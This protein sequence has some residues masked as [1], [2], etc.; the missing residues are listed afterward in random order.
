[1]KT[2][3]KILYAAVAVAILVMATLTADCAPGD[4]FASINNGPGNGVG[5]IYQ[6]TPAGVQSTVASGLSHPRGLAFDS[7]ANLF[8]AT[9]F[10]K[11]IRGTLLC[12][13]TILQIAPNGAQSVFAT[14][15]AFFATGVAIDHSDNVFVM[16]WQSTLAP[17]GPSIIYKFT[18]DGKRKQFGLIN[19]FQSFDLAFDSAGNLFASS[20]GEQTIYKF[21][22]DGSPSVFVGPSAFG[23][24]GGPIGLAFDPFGNLFVSN[25]TFPF[26]NDTILEFTPGGVKSTFATGLDF[27]RGLAFDSAGNLFV[28]DVGG[29]DAGAI[30]KTAPDGTQTV[31]ASG[32]GDPNGNGGP[33]YLAI[34]PSSVP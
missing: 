5:S 33:E 15:P 18:P 22:P 4:I 32:I 7:A 31:F 16:T 17:K 34:Q 27:P 2:I 9:N 6:Y 26:N 28:A 23:Q 12:D 13:S 10:C 19:I 24:L 1:M 20:T 11:N 21:A 29:F 3:T 14:I 25:E 8:V 30:I